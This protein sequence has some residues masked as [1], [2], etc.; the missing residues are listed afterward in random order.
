MQ[1]K[2]SSAAEE[3]GIK[4]LKGIFLVLF[5]GCIFA[6]FYGCVES[7][8]TIYRKAKKNKVLQQFVEHFII[9]IAMHYN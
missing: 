8:L 4:N 9:S 3:L 5:L 2:D 1:E 6:C 7:L